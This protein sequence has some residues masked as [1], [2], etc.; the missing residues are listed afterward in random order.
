MKTKTKRGIIFLVLSAAVPV[1]G[2]LLFFAAFI[3]HGACTEWLD[4]LLLEQILPVLNPDAP[5]RVF[6]WI[7]DII[8]YFMYTSICAI[9]VL[10]YSG[11]IRLITPRA[12]E[13]YLTPKLSLWT[14]VIS[15]TCGV[16]I[17]TVIELFGA[18]LATGG[19]FT[20]PNRLS[21]L[22]IFLPIVFVA[23]LVLVFVYIFSWNGKRDPAGNALPVRVI[24]LDILR[25]I[26]AFPG[27]TLLA[28]I[29]Y[30]ILL[31]LFSNAF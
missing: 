8:R 4:N 5:R 11:I 28:A 21:A 16:G 27:Y 10:L 20:Y 22:S 17:V 15:A 13:V 23:F 1:A 14:N 25:G 2:I 31:I 12:E 3:L 7:D 9:P 24:F 26:L 6:V 29:G 19:N 30:H 18:I